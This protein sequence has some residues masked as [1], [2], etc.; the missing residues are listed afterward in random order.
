[1]TDRRRAGGIRPF[2]P[3][4]SLLVVGV[5]IAI[6]APAIWSATHHDP[7][8]NTIDPGIAVRLA[9]SD[10]TAGRTTAAV[11][12]LG[13]VPTAIAPGSPGATADAATSARP[14]A[15]RSTASGSGRHSAPSAG[16]AVAHPAAP[17]T[18]ASTAVTPPVA[19]RAVTPAVSAPV[20]LQIPSVGINA[21]LQAVGLDSRGD[22]AV[23]EQ[24]DVVGWYKFG[25]APGAA[26]GS[27]VLSGH[28]DSAQQGL[29]AFSAL[30]KV[31]SGDSIT[32][33]DASGRRWRYRVVGREAFDKKTV[34]LADLFSRSGAARLTLITCGGDF[35]ASIRSYVD[36]IVVTAVP[37]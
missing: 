5:V 1:M 27:A 30:V 33:T 13:A 18:V 9:E 20:R 35:D 36:N 32:V 14:T 24:V 31:K 10:P 11:G 23:P 6:G 29:G 3:A 22:M 7:T 12:T 34:P 2:V 4:V 8:L 21:P 26:T 17:T 16:T 25:P 28:I 15:V 19:R 37:G